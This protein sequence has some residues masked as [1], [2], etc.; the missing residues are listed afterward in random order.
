M[1]FLSEL[2]Q[3][4]AVSA[5]LVFLV[6]SVMHMLLPIHKG[7]FSR[8]ANEDAVLEALRSKGV[9]PGNYM[10]PFAASM[11]EL[12]SPGMLEKFRK[13]PAGSLI[14]RPAGPPA[15]GR[16][17]GQWFLFS[18][19]VGLLVAYV[20]W[21]ALGRGADYLLVFQLTGSV[22]W[23]GYGFGHLQDSI[24]KGVKWSTSFKFLLDGLVYGLVTAG[25]FGW[26]WPR[27]L[28]A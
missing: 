12:G 16:A 7:D 21:H 14:V 9:G 8:L 24:W 13:G 27:A 11:Q 28:G 23:L 3:P 26:L 5:A 17:L 10:F 1:E 4:I 20:A 18:L 22:A 25:A 19:A 2:W 6:S 15:M